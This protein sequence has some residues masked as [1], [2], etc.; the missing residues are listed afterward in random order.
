MMTGQT[1]SVARRKTRVKRATKS[2]L[3]SARPALNS[4]AVRRRRARLLALI[5]RTQ[6]PARTRVLEEIYR[7]FQRA[8]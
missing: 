7:D 5:N 6:S 2:A 1:S 4:P 8:F 3:S